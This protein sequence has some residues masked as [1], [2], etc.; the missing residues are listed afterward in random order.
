MMNYTRVGVETFEWVGPIIGPRV[1]TGMSG[2]AYLTGIR[3]GAVP[4]PELGPLITAEL[5]EIVHGRAQLICSASEPQFGL[6]RELDPGLA[7]LLIS[8]AVSCV[9]QTLTGLGQGWATVASRSSYARPSSPQVGNL[10]ATAEVI[11]LYE[12]RALV[13]GELLDECGLV[14]A[15][16]TTTIDV[17]DL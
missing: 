1:E 4:P 8:V 6:M 11:D 14:L 16:T 3:D 5:I 10:V 7:G 13:K 17:F 2:L 9:A 12:G 15:T